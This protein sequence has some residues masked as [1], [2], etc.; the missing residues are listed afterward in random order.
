MK[1]G[2]EEGRGRK[3]RRRHFMLTVTIGLKSL[4]PCDRMH[5][6]VPAITPARCE[7]Y[8]TYWSENRLSWC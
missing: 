4:L 8:L 3:R 6:R 5:I 2:V 7:A 1:G